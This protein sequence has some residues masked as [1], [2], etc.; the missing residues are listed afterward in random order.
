M[1]HS[2]EPA[3]NR[4]AAFVGRAFVRAGLGDPLGADGD[5]QAAV[6]LC[7]SS[8]W[9]YY[10]QGRV[11]HQRGETVAATHCFRLALHVDRPRLTPRQRERAE[12][13]VRSHAAER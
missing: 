6:P 9:M 13:Y 8:A 1:R 2:P 7:P 11:Y 4:G 3:P 5:F 12:A 10:Q